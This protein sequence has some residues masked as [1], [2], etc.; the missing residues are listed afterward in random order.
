MSKKQRIKKNYTTS[1]VVSQSSLMEPIP[2][3]RIGMI[4]YYPFLFTIIIYYLFLIVVII[5][6]LIIIIIM[7]I[8]ILT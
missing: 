6:N 2:T 3:G 8:I 4:H 1:M 7:I 5:N